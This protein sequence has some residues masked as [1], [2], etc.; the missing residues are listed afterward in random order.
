MG[1]VCYVW[2]VCV[3]GGWYVVCVLGMGG[4]CVLCVGCVWVVCVCVCVCVCVWSLYRKC[5]GYSQSSKGKKPGHLG[6]RGLGGDPA[7]LSQA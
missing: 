7:E 5:Y 2:G 3:C 6:T 1:S 4:V